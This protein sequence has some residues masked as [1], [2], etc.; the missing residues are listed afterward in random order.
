MP[1]GNKP[2]VCPVKPVFGP[3][4]IALLVGAFLCHYTEDWELSKFPGTCD[5]N[6]VAEGEYLDRDACV[7]LYLVRKIRG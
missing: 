3:R 6:M 1:F 2:F 5:V 4:M 7:Q